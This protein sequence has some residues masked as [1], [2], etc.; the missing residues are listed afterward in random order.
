MFMRFW[1]GLLQKDS[2]WNSQCLLVTCKYLPWSSRKGRMTKKSKE[3]WVPSPLVPTSL[4]T[5]KFCRVGNHPETS[6]VHETQVDASNK[7]TSEVHNMFVRKSGFAPPPQHFSN[8]CQKLCKMRRNLSKSGSPKPCFRQNSSFLPD[9]ITV[10]VLMKTAKMT[11]L[12]STNQKQRLCSSD[13][14]K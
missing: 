11:N 3:K 13:R 8:M 5:S 7:S 6:T 14:Q 9:F 12:H 2:E 1:L 10:G 4:R